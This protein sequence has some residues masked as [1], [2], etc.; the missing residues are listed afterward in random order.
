[1]ETTLNLNLTV[2]DEDID[3][4]MCS[5]VEGG[6]ACLWVSCVEPS[7][8][9]WKTDYVSEHVGHGGT[10]ILKCEKGK[11][12]I[13]KHTVVSGLKQYLERSLNDKA[14]VRGDHN[15]SLSLDTGYLDAD[16]ADS[17]IQY[18]LFGEIVYS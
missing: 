7:E 8:G 2:T 18:G 11:F 13:T 5:F 14:I 16:A 6:V 10:M 17:I 12:A 3:D 9:A 15:N 4:I 1:M